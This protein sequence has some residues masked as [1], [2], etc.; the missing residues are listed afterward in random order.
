MQSFTQN[1]SD[2]DLKKTLR[3]HYFGY[4]Y[5]LITPVM[6]GLVSLYLIYHIIA[7]PGLP[8]PAIWLLLIAGAFFI[9]RPR[10][11]IN[12]IFSNIKARKIAEETMSI[13]LT[14]D[15]KISSVVGESQSLIPL[16]ELHRYADKQDFF[17]L[18]V[19]K[20]N[21]LVLDKREM[22]TG[23]LNKLHDIMEKYNIRKR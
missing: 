7:N 8:E 22:P 16:K 10:L 19:S 23:F 20:D 14:D 9:L 2:K 18:Y 1:L 17:F 12:R 6:G 5:T 13:T 4:K 15:E 21:F 3:I 11:Y